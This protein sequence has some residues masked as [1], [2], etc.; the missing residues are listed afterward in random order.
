M[1]QDPP[2][3][4]VK[5]R[6]FLPHIVFR[7]RELES[8]RSKAAIGDGIGEEL[9]QEEEWHHCHGRGERGGRVETNQRK[10][11]GGQEVHRE[12]LLAAWQDLAREATEVIVRRVSPLLSLDMVWEL[13]EVLAWEVQ[14]YMHR[15]I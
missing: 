1:Q 12:S 2:P 4:L 9:V 11:R 8:E 14:M 6:I 10:S 13:R 7:N 3:Y 5:M 15:S